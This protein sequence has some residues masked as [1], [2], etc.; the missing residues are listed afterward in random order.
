MTES[1]GTAKL[2]TGHR[3]SNKTAAERLRKESEGLEE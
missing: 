1:F 3:R 2:V